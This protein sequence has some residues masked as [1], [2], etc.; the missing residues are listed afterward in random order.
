[1]L[2]GIFFNKLPNDEGRCIK[3]EY[4]DAHGAHQ[5]NRA[6]RGAKQFSRRECT[7]QAYQVE[8]SLFKNMPKRR[9]NSM[10]NGLCCPL[11]TAK[12]K[13]RRPL[14]IL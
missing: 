8:A 13:G 5:E 6:K 11:A 4:C 7:F 1:M 3:I 12:Q 10:Q 2:L 14:K 9:E